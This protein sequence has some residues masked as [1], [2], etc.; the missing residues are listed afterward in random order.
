[1]PIRW[2]DDRT[3]SSNSAHSGFTPLSRAPKTFAGQLASPLASAAVIAPRSI[4]R[5]DTRK[6]G[7]SASPSGRGVLIVAS[8]EAEFSR[9]VETHD[10]LKFRADSDIDRNLI[11]LA[12]RAVNNLNPS[13]QSERFL[14]HYPTDP[15]IG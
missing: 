7:S 15:D 4:V 1:M 9:D 13:T 14:R 10:L 8:D 12:R 3:A 6:P 2:N 5:R 11:Y